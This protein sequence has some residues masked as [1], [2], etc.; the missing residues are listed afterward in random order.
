MEI[1]LPKVDVS[2]RPI[3]FNIGNEKTEIINSLLTSSQKQSKESGH[4][5]LERAIL[6]HQSTCS[7]ELSD[8]MKVHSFQLDIPA[9]INHLKSSGKYDRNFQNSIACLT[10][11]LIDQNNN[12]PD[13]RLLRWKQD[14]DLLA[15]QGVSAT[16]FDFITENGSLFLIKVDRR[17]FTEG[18]PIAKSDLTHEAFI[19]L[20][21]I[22][23]L[24]NKVPNFVHTYGAFF[25]A[26]PI[27]EDN[28]VKVWCPTQVDDVTYLLMENIHDNIQLSQGILDNKL[29]NSECI[30]IYLQVINALNVAYQ[31]NK[32]THYDLHTSNVLVQFLPQ[33]V[34]IPIYLAN[35]GIKYLVTSVLARIIDYGYSYSE[36]SN[37]N[38]GYFG[39]ENILIFPDKPFP[40][41]DAHKLLCYMGLL[42]KRAKNSRLNIELDKLYNFFLPYGGISLDKFIEKNMTRLR[43]YY[44]PD[45]IEFA[46]K[47]IDVN[48]QA[49]LDF[50]I[51]V[52]PNLLVDRKPSNVLS[53]VC[54]DKCVNWEAFSKIAFNTTQL[55]T[56]I[57]EYCDTLRLINEIVPEP[58][59]TASEKWLTQYDKY[60][61]FT[62]E[63]TL[64]K[65]KLDNIIVQ[66]PQLAQK[67]DP[68]N[69]EKFWSFLESLLQYL[70]DL[71]TVKLWETS[72]NCA[73]SDDYDEV[74]EQINHLHNLIIGIEVDMQ[75]IKRKISESPASDDP[76][77]IQLVT[78]IFAMIPEE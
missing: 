76:R 3:S 73:F 66:Y 28:R 70:Y 12:R 13:D 50:I 46:Q 23:R 7:M 9:V 24:R 43:Y 41:H 48:Y 8:Q 77:M 64:M 37:T 27:V 52:Y 6:S 78:Y 68:N 18:I 47:L 74:A 53:S 25:C 62:Q 56:S 4:Y 67:Y 61:A 60:S 21:V 51:T 19:G 59:R 44:Q 34:S 20:G 16:I 71:E 30:S 15:D 36:V 42:A 38:F 29:T 63:Y 26:P 58:K 72:V 35:G 40:M 69:L 2:L 11:S 17:S 33:P 49:M 10:T 1:P 45:P 32:F 55:P 31:A 65:D 14:I 75:N 54:G 22:N 57:S 5:E 39:F